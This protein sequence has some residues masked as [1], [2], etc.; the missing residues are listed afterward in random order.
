MASIGIFPQTRE[1]KYWDSRARSVAS[2]YGVDPDFFT[3]LIGSESAWKTYNPSGTGPI[4]IGQFTRDTAKEWGVIRGNPES[5]LDGAARYIKYLIN[6]A[7]GDIQ[8]AVY[9]YKGHDYDAKHAAAAESAWA[10]IQTTVKALKGGI[11]PQAFTDGAGLGGVYPN[12]Q[13]AGSAPGGVM[14]LP[15]A[16]TLAEYLD[17]LTL[18]FI[19]LVL[20][21]IVYSVNAVIKS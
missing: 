6:R 21:L 15:G 17:P 9:D 12:T 1:A 14:R 10:K 18:F 2:N 11:I 7:K 3:T 19:V 8:K 20:T 16:S 5:E 4:G 13:G